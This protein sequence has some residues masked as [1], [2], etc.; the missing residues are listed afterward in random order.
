[1]AVGELAGGSLEE[2]ERLLALATRQS[3]SVPADRRGRFQVVLTVSR[4]RLARRRGDL[5]AV[6]EESDR[7]LAAVEAPDATQFKLGEDLRALA[8]IFLGVAEVWAFRFKD[9]SEHL[10]LGVAL[11]HRIE[12]P[13]LELM[14]LAHVAQLAVFRSYH[15]RSAAE[16]AGDRAGAT[17][18]LERDA[19]HR[20]RLRGA[21]R[22]DG[23]PGTAGGGRAVAWARRAHTSTGGRT[24]RRE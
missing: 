13:F 4:L 10:E 2:A 20:R 18:R 21:R 5:P 23:L 3:A 9:A 19:G 11:A 12:R 15:A 8:L 24:S 1:M 14:G 6:V 7:L 16:Q 17:A 22:R